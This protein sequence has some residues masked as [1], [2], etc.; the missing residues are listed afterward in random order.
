MRVILDT[1]VLRS[2]FIPADSNPYKIVQAWIGRFEL[3]ARIVS[4][5]SSAT[6]LGL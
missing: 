4:V 3:E 6:Q 1:N 2:T 5:A